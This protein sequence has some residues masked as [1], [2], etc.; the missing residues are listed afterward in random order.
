MPSRFE[1]ERAVRASEL[2]SLSRLVA[3][4]LATWADVATGDIS[5]RHT[6]SLS[7][8]EVCTG[9]ARASVRKHLDTLEKAGWVVRRRP[10]PRKAR[11]EKARTQYALAIPTGAAG[12]LVGDQETHPL[13]Q[14]TPQSD[15]GLGQEAPQARAGAALALGQEMST[16]RAGAAPKSSP[17]SEEYLSSSSTVLARPGDDS[18]E[19]LRPLQEAMSARG[20]NLPWKFH[21]DDLIRLHLDIKRLGVPLMVQHAESK[22][23]NSPRG[24][25]SSRFFYDDWHRIKT[26]VPSDA[27]RLSVVGESTSDKRLRE[28]TNLIDHYRR[29]EAGEGTS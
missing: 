25:F 7:T 4:T 24:A 5:E 18:P 9:M 1:Y 14:Q 16:T 10:D 19:W 28:G 2:P 22:I 29:L 15:A 21:G 13:G 12:A 26:P 23:S 8:L 27:P 11:A 17:P 20:I 6:P 3:L